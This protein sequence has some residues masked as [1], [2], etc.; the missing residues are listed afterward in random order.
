MM[1]GP[2]TVAEKTGTTKVPKVVAVVVASR[3]FD[4]NSLIN[5]GYLAR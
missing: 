3:R 4:H 1:F 2:G 5:N